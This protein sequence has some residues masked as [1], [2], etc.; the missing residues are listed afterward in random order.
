M[1]IICRDRLARRPDVDR[2]PAVA[3]R[4]GDGLLDHVD[5]L[6]RER[7][8]R[9]E[10]RRERDELVEGGVADRDPAQLREAVADG[11]E[12]LAD[13]GRVHRLDG[14]LGEAP[15][16]RRLRLEQRLVLLGGR[17]ADAGDLAP[18]QRRLEGL[19][20][21]L[22]AG[23]A[24]WWISSKKTTTEGWRTSTRKSP[25]SD[26]SEPTA[27]ASASNGMSNRWMSRSGGGT[28]PAAIRQG[29]AP[30]RSRSC[31][32]RRPQQQ[33]VPL[34]AAEQDLDDRVELPLAA[35]DRAQLAVAGEA[36]EVA[37]E[38]LERRRRRPACRPGD[39]RGDGVV[40]VDRRLALD[41][42]VGDR[43]LEQVDRLVG[44]ASVQDRRVGEVEQDVDGVVADR[45]AAA[46]RERVADAQQDRP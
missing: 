22:A 31:R 32:S 36:D 18:G 15:G 27:E 38:A 19:R 21:V 2:G 29:P 35:D 26:G 34:R 33:R 20:E 23:F 3:D 5:A 39:R 44:E 6:V 8:V 28:E 25:R 46:L 12:D 37:A 16:E 14:D 7:A 13:R 1:P 24:S 10:L 40:A 43:L 30:P 9:E 17:R 11:H 41:D 42:G 4:I 45:D